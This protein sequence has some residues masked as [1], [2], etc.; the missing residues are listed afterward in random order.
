M[1][2]AQ[3]IVF[4]VF[5]Y[6]VSRGD[7]MSKKILLMSVAALGLAS[8]VAFANGQIAAAPIGTA[9]VSSEDQQAVYFGIQGG[10]AD[11]GLKTVL[12]SINGFSNEFIGQDVIHVEKSESIAGRVFLGYDVN[13]YFAF[14]AG[15]LYLF[16]KT[17]IIDVPD[18]IELGTIQTQAIDLVAKIKAPLTDD[19]GLYAKVGPG[20]LM[21][22][23]K[24]IDGYSHSVDKIDLVYGAGIYYNITPEVVM[25]LSWTRYN[26]GHTAMDKNWQPSPVD[27]YALGISYK[28]PL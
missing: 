12:E 19:A 14:E 6:N 5:Y 11:T 24:S 28:L 4:Y 18:G 22:N 1:D 7:K 21:L 27:F 23:G 8:S 9:A 26:S 15:Y 25:D 16:E 2:F 3:F 20:Y 13:K 10:Y 17:K